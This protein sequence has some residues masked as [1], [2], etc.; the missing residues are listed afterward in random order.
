MNRR[1]RLVATTAA[2]L[3]GASLALVAFNIV[4]ATLPAP[5]I[6]NGDAQNSGNA[7]WME[8]QAQPDDGAASVKQFVATFLVQHAVGRTINNVRIDADFNATDNASTGTLVPVTSQTFVAAAGGIETSRVTVAIA[9]GKPGG[10]SCPL[11]GSATRSVDA[12]VRMRVQDTT[13]EQSATVSTTVKFVEDAQ[14]AG[15]ADFPRMTGVSQNLTE[16]VPGQ[17]ITYTFSCDDVDTDFFSSDDDCDRANIRWRRLNDGDTSAITLKTGIDD[18]TN[19][20][21]AVSFPSRGFYVVEAQLGNEDGAFPNLGGA[22]G[23]WWRL[24][25]AVVND[26]ASSL[27]GSIAMGGAQPSSPPSVNPG[28]PVTATATAADA[29]GAVQ[30]IEWDADGNGS[31]E[32]REYT[33]PANSGGNIVHPALTS[34]ELD[35]SVNTATAGLKTINARVTDNGALDAA[36]NIRRQ[37]TFSAQLRVN[38]I[39]TA[40]NV[41][42]GT[43]EDT[44]VVVTMLG[45]DADG[46]P[47]PLTY[48]IVSAP[49]GSEG[50]LSV[51]S[52]A[53]VTFTPA[54]N[55]NGTT[56]FTY[57]VEDG[58][59]STVGAH[60][61][62]NTAT[63]NIVVAA[64]NDAPVANDQSLTT[65]E[66]TPLNITLTASD[67]EGDTLTF[68]AGAPAHGSISGTGANITYTP[69][70]DYN[71]PDSFS[72]SVSDG[73]G[74]TDVGQVDI[75]VTPVQDGPV[76]N[77]QTVNTQED[78]SVSITLTGSDV[79]GDTLSFSVATSPANGS[80]AGTA[81]NLIYSPAPNFN[82]TD[83]F[84]FTVDDG[85]GNTDTATVTIVVAA[86]NDAPVADDQSV[87]TAEDTPLSI[88]LTGSDVDGD[89]L[90]FSVLSGPN[91]GSLAGT[92]PNL[93]Y[94]PAQDYFGPDSFT[95]QV[96]DGNGGT[97]TGIVSIT[98]TPVNDPPVAIDQ[99]KNTGEDT[100]VA[101]GLTATDVDGPALT[102]SVVSPPAN[103]TLSGTPPNLVY[104]PGLNYTGPDQFTFAVSDGE[105][106]DT[107]TVDINVGTSNDPPLADPQ[108]VSTDED[109][110]LGI[111]LTG[112]D[113]DG[114]PLMF[115][116]TGGPSHGSLSG[117]APNLTYTP[118]TDYVGHD[119]FTFQAD[120]GKGGIDTATVDINVGGVNDPPLGDDQSVT[121]AED[122]PI[123]INLT[124]SDVDGDTLSFSVVGAPVNG[125]LTGSGDFVIYSP[126][127]NYN[128]P[129]SF[130]FLVNDGN[131]G[132]DTATVDITVTAVNDTPDAVPQFVTV[133]EDTATA[134]TLS[135]TDA[136]G[137]PL[138]YTVTAPPSHGSLSGTAP[139]LTY[140]PAADYNGTD[141]FTFEVNDGNGGVS[142]AVVSINVEAAPLI[143][144][145]LIP[146]GAV[147][148]VELNFGVPTQSRIAVLH[149]S[150]TLFDSSGD[151]LAGRTLT[152]STGGTVVCTAV[153]DASGRGFC[154]DNVDAA[155]ALLNLG[156][157]VNF[158]GDPDYAP[159][160]ANGSIVQ[161]NVKPT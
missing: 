121:T 95:F 106:T 149:L 134:I 35:Q 78:T 2:A 4:G 68:L 127:L 113:A 119:L 64:V 3:L 89:T 101:V 74:G 39:P 23:G 158:A 32:R 20:T 53:Q 86:V 130:T 70:Q 144:T 140:T 143:G 96:D 99:V 131:G 15:K 155:M 79:D 107:G 138:T 147:L 133:P 58:T 52:G 84:T 115:S 1:K 153:T 62:S 59:A 152:F 146:D 54:P 83:S 10:F 67:V 72:F 129:D 6:L 151:P 145:Y 90:G 66:D 29:G 76:A 5:I 109:T 123:A 31:F 63:V 103:G 118:A 105:F 85:N 148:D 50:S 65:Q 12:P 87:T 71:G 108:A 30:A 80:L 41:N 98:V 34:G 111:T 24:G 47:E 161:V 93:V 128:G 94:T 141:F 14:C 159:S 132:T 16:V 137:D 125:T 43:N 114:D 9:I 77:P 48:S 49:P 135:A 92:A 154:S 136:D 104:T 91:H 102:F 40:A 69:D 17:N 36:D 73:N 139:N 56:S 25:N 19:T 75:D 61:P 116:V 33:V 142:S 55:F 122:S 110:P 117:T 28:S 11:I 150:A 156:Y 13:N 81:P 22:S 38:A 27:S 124:G 60:A 21:H 126:G 18:N 160:S 37:L 100:P 45:N 8:T 97:D 26:A 157:Q 44:P 112:S 57:R 51:V 120:D 46:Q 82:G 7:Q 88:T 42:T